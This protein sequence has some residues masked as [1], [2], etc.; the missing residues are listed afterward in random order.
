MCIHS[1]PICNHSR[2]CMWVALQ[3]SVL[4]ASLDESRVSPPRSADSP[5]D[6][7]QGLQKSDTQGMESCGWNPQI[8]ALRV[9]LALVTCML[10]LRCS[11]AFFLKVHSKL[12]IL[13]TTYCLLPTTHCSLRTTHYSLLTTHYSLLTTHYSL[14]TTHYSLL[15]T[16][17]SRLTTRYSLL[18]THYS[19]L[20]THYSLL[21]THYPLLTTHYPL[22]LRRTPSSGSLPSV[23]CA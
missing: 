11:E 17:Y 5:G 12:G 18:T 9:T 16:H 15:T 14:R 23:P 22:S 8:E 20:T 13:F 2:P 10:F 19:L 1:R 7:I 21:T 3:A 4:R 6:W